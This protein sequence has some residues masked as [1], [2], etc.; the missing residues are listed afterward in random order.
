MDGAVSRLQI[1]QIEIV[2]VPSL[3]KECGRGKP[4]ATVPGMEVQQDTDERIKRFL[5]DGRPNA[6]FFVIQW[7]DPATPLGVDIGSV[8]IIGTQDEYVYGEAASRIY[9]VGKYVCLPDK[10][11][12][13]GDRWHQML[14]FL[15]SQEHWVHPP[16]ESA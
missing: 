9:R 7:S 1:R 2:D 16:L 6:T 10:E 12:P 14:I 11:D 4:S 5:G 13:N 15:R 8:R 3:A